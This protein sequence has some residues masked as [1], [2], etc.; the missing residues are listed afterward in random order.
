MPV[1]INSS[2]GEFVTLAQLRDHLNMTSLSHDAE[3]ARF[4]G[5]AQEH[6][7]ALVGPV[8]QS[9]VTEDVRVVGSTVVLSECPVVDVYSVTVA[10]SELTG[11]T[12]RP[13]AGLV[14]GVNASGTATV[15]YSTGRTSCPDGVATAALII[16]EHLWRT[17]LGGSPSALPV[18]DMAGMPGGSGFAIP[19]R[20]M[21]LLAPYLKAP[22]VA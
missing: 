22:G 8:L 15:T 18:D 2:T 13:R 11:W 16:A 9:S 10:G 1:P 5:A 19:R 12:L 21:E 7:E 6:V 3:L 17:Q 14:T 4:L 20:A